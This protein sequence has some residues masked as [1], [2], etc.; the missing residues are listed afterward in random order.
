MRRLT[1]LFLLLHV[2]AFVHAE[3]PLT[4]K[5]QL[6]DEI[7]V[8]RNEL[9]DLPAVDYIKNAYRINQLEARVLST[10]NES[11]IIYFYCYYNQMCFYGGYNSGD[12]ERIQYGLSKLKKYIKKNK[13]ALGYYYIT[14]GGIHGLQGRYND[15]DKETIKAHN[16]FLKYGANQDLVRSYYLLSYIYLGKN[17]LEEGLSLAKNA[18]AC[19]NA[20][21]P[22]QQRKSLYVIYSLANLLCFRSYVDLK[23]YDKATP[24][25]H[26]LENNTFF[27]P[28]KKT[29]YHLNYYMALY[30]NHYNNRK[31]TEKLLNM[32]YTLWKDMLKEVEMF[33][34]EKAEL[35]RKTIEGLKISQ[36]YE[37]QRKDAENKNIMLAFGCF[38]ILVLSVLVYYQNWIQKKIKKL[39][40]A[41]SD[42]NTVLSEALNSRS[43]FFNTVS[44]EFKTPLHT[45]KNVLQDTSLA[46]NIPAELLETLHSSI[47]SLN[48]LINNV[49]HVHK[50]EDGSHNVT[51]EHSYDLKRCIVEAFES[52]F[53]SDS[54]FIKL[55][56][57]ANIDSSLFLDYL[58]ITQL[59]ENIF[60]IPQMF[61]NLG[62]VGVKVTIKKDTFESQE[63][64]IA[65]SCERN[66]ERL[67]NLN[68]SYLSAFN[69]PINESLQFE[70]GK[71]LGLSVIKKIVSQYRGN[72]ILKENTMLIS[73][74]FKKA[75]K[76]KFEIE[77][78]DGNQSKH[79]L[80]V[81]DE[82][83]NQMLTKKL[84][85]ENGFICDVANNGKEAV[86]KALS[87]NYDLILMDIMMP[88]MDGFEASKIIKEKTKNPLIV[89]LSAIDQ[90][91]N[92]E[93]IVSSGIKYFMG[94]PIEKGDFIKKINTYIS[95]ANLNVG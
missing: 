65:C 17:K 30:F 7:T 4:T 81:E 1:I 5:Q 3:I 54:N 39:N 26:I 90:A 59:F 19:Y 62:D 47:N 61:P 74:V 88:V 11:L 57:D 45:I 18:I 79:L 91:L 27:S 63:I 36:K 46:V 51:N 40:D 29:R 66:I 22:N 21:P 82:K 38:I 69:T 8:L 93:K 42:K 50:L 13:V 70:S 68:E 31:Q 35:K 2:I 41:L 78:K 48:N 84:I 71:K 43:V 9:G 83:L 92:N 85:E 75:V 56:I 15:R 72:V 53:L 87:F 16:V 64:Q 86:E 52:K 80:L 94:K 20:I 60:L 33:G 34:N 77:L 12:V 76:Y 89:A 28:Q 32:S 67:V 44:H 23:Q 37:I 6:D 58:K 14:L 95:E 10:K 25:L 73:M 49:I 24:F 55:T